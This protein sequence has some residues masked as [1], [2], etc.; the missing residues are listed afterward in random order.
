VTRKLGAGTM[1][2]V[3]A[4]YDPDLSRK[5]A[6]KI[7][8]NLPGAGNEGRVRI[9][10]EAQAMA[11]LSHPNIVAVFDVGTAFEQVFIA[12]EFVERGSLTDWLK[13]PHSLTELLAM[14]HQAGT[15]LLAAHKAG[16]VHRDFKPDN[17]LIDHDGRARVADFGLARE[18]SESELAKLGG[19]H[20][21]PSV[22]SLP[23][24]ERTSLGSS[25]ALKLNVTQAGSLM[26]TPRYMAPEQ[27][28]GRAVDQ[29]TD[30]FSFCVA[31]Y[32]ALYGQQPF[33]GE[34]IGDLAFNV[35][36][37][38]IQP[39]PAGKSVPSDI[40]RALLRGMA[41][42]PDARFQSMEPLLE[43]ISPE[44]RQRRRS[45]VLS[46]VLLVAV[47]LAAA[48]ALGAL[49][50]QRVVR[51][52]A[53]N[54]VGAR[55]DAVWGP[56]RQAQ[57]K[58][59]LLAAHPSLGEDVF[60]RVSEQVDG[61][62][63]RWRTARA[64]ICATDVAGRPY[65]VALREKQLRCLDN[66]LTPAIAFGDVLLKA[67]VEIAER[68]PEVSRDLGDLEACED[69]IYVRALDL[70]KPE[71][72]DTVRGLLRNIEEIR[73]R[74]RLGQYVQARE[75]ARAAVKGT[76]SVSYSP[77]R[78]RA[79]MTLAQAEILNGDKPA[80][81]K[82]FFAAAV[83]GLRG[84]DQ[85]LAMEAFLE[86]VRLYAQRQQL[87]IAERWRELALVQLER[88]VGNERSKKF[89]RA[90]IDWYTCELQREQQ[91]FAHAEQSC[92]SA[93]RLHQELFGPESA[94]ASGIMNTL[95]LTYQRQD[96]FNEALVLYHQTYALVEKSI[97]PMHP[98][99]AV[100]L[101][102]LGNLMVS[103][104]RFDEAAGYYQKVVEIHK[105]TL[106]D[107]H[108]KL[109]DDYSALARANSGRGRHD[110]AVRF[111]WSALER[112][113]DLPDPTKVA[114][115][116]FI[117]GE[118]LQRAGRFEEAL[119]AHE[120]ALDLCDQKSCGRNLPAYTTAV[121]EDRIELGQVKAAIPDL[122]NALRLQP[123]PPADRAN[124]ART[125]FA[126]ARALLKA[127][128][129]RSRPRAVELAQAALAHYREVGHS[130]LPEQE[131]V[132]TWLTRNTA[133]AAP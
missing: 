105:R 14:F 86:M 27:F 109:F 113:Q 55:L 53:C 62:L 25:Q 115:G 118:M 98:R 2:I 19:A 5:V 129:K 96:K 83:S 125:E 42:D 26:G 131:E 40:H 133:T 76:E 108:P 7:L 81:D 31:L 90:R 123:D 22:P 95:A 80:A 91:D 99:L 84:G 8:R 20:V 73:A 32:E 126:L 43:A 61:F 58:A 92:Q 63:K 94:S 103:H 39:P 107:R 88:M 37:G 41:V 28:R 59:A 44:A 85:R 101:N 114:A 70:E 128:P 64:G 3:Y 21:E 97:G 77:I 15:G 132:Q 12:M 33:L 122:E 36:Q 52:R 60:Q 104:Q 54:D 6:I 69:T 67:D 30:V 23:P 121:A 72:R 87:D 93:L 56:A 127:D 112:V 50:A 9:F 111:G 11:R 89:Y 120:H 46:V 82:S 71:E 124:K 47:L 51:E 13:E 49:R 119:S 38:K 24:D 116:H 117:L 4:A 45:R 130:A 29:R 75:M 106:G 10:R 100:Y 17:V 74:A 68:A 1:G 35:T 18:L 34:G 66:Q 16:L 48:G 110:D 79:L 78:G 65:R 57:I 102:N